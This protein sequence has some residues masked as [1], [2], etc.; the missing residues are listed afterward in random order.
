[1]LAGAH[2]YFA[3]FAGLRKKQPTAN[4]RAP[5]YSFP[6]VQ[7]PYRA[8]APEH[9]PSSQGTIEYGTSI[10]HPSNID[11]TSNYQARHSR[12][13]QGKHRAEQGG[14]RVAKA[15]IGQSKTGQ[16]EARPKQSK[17]RAEQGRAGQAK[18]RQ[19]HG[20]KQ[21]RPSQTTECT[22]PRSTGQAKVKQAHGRMRRSRPSQTTTSTWQGEAK[23][24][25]AQS[26][27]RRRPGQTMAVEQAKPNYD[28]HA[29]RRGQ[30][31]A[32]TE[33]NKAEEARPNH[34]RSRRSK[35][36][37]KQG[38]HK[39]EQGVQARPK[40]GRHN[41][42]RR[43]RPGQSPESTGQSQAP[44]ARPKQAKRRAEQGRASQAEARQAQG[45]ARHKRRCKIESHASTVQSR[46]GQA[47]PGQS[48]A[49]KAEQGQ[50][51]SGQAKAK[52]GEAGQAK[53]RQAKA[54]G[55]QLSLLISVFVSRGDLAGTW[56]RWVAAG[57]RP[58][59]TTTRTTRNT[60]S[61]TTHPSNAPREK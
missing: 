8:A 44:Q 12:P 40:D 45:T 16:D 19:A 31:K 6:C 7:D 28:K 17:H 43:S 4:T 48:K 59:P 32:S 54:R 15:H 37:P 50:A 55:M 3:K 60:E 30:S 56:N 34:G 14:A 52:E 58:G 22:G 51:T 1:V 33:Q 49:H 10:Q 35:A 39:A 61:R 53:A 20:R 13:R 25:Q 2:K 42:E 47:R 41:K 24:R 46:A 18:A 27:T 36:G 21:S 29:V 23:A 5:V 26:R 57:R 38:K 11:R 9:P